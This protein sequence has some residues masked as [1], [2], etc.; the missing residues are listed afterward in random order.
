VARRNIA[1]VYHFFA[2]YRQPV[3]EELLEKSKHHF[4]LCAGTKNALM[5]F[6]DPAVSRACGDLIP[7]RYPLVVQRQVIDAAIDAENADVVAE[8]LAE[9]A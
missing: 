4:L 5:P 3:L 7:R 2:H 1:L 6:V 9:V 8:R